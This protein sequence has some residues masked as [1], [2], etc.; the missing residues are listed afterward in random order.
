MDGEYL[1]AIEA[2]DID[3]LVD[4]EDID[5]YYDEGV[6]SEDAEDAEDFYSEFPEDAEARYS[7]AYRRSR[8][9]RARAARQRAL[10][11]ARAARARR[12]RHPRMRTAPSRRRRYYPHHARG[13][14]ST[15]QVGKGFQRVGADIQKTQTVLR[16]VDLESKVQADTL[17][18]ALGVQRKRITGSEYAFASSLV[19][20]ELKSQ[21]PE[22]LENKV[23]QTALPLAPLL[24]LKPR[25][26]GSGVDSLFYDPR[27]LG[28]LLAAGIAIFKNTTKDKDIEKVTVNP[29]V[30]KIPVTGGGIPFIATARD[31]DSKKIEGRKFNWFSSDPTIA[32]VDS[33]GI[34]TPVAAGNAQILA[35]EEATETRGSASIVVTKAVVK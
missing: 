9:R 11:R 3:L 15:Q 35:I 5:D 12:M 16:K 24:F 31:H 7:A 30:Q 2:E 28:A 17:A 20:N 23:I 1:D 8:A 32:T 19:V 18:S 25:K 22:I 27:I 21:F 13:T 4:G 26:K 33:N 6:E 29:P 34:V 14:A 10:A